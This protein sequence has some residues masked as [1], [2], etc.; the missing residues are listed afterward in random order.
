MALSNNLIMKKK[1]NFI[2]KYSDYFK[3]LL[4]ANKIHFEITTCD[5]VDITS[6]MVSYQV[7]GNRDEILLCDIFNLY[8]GKD[9]QKQ[10]E[11]L[12][13]F[14]VPYFSIDSIINI[15]GTF[16]ISNQYV[17]IFT[18]FMKDH[19][20]NFRIVTES[21]YSTRID[22]LLNSFTRNMILYYLEGAGITY[23]INFKTFK[24]TM[25]YMY[26][27]FRDRKMNSRYAGGHTQIFKNKESNSM[28]IKDVIFNGPATIV[29]WS[30]G[31]KTVVKCENETFDPEKGLAMAISKK[32][33]GNHS[34]YYNQFK[35]WIPE[36]H[37]TDF[38][39]A[40]QNVVKT[41]DDIKK[42]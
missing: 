31:T 11:R 29:M 39:T 23:E 33:F 26:G 24:E 12:S 14:T 27:Y 5:I 7:T 16:Y 36:D 1:Y 35:K 4:H 18:S 9:N 40:C 17:E 21:G 20:I 37:I 3:K 25:N 2:N 34:S 28:Y 10:C 38:D 13:N 15:C 6:L 42:A 32:F 30:D 22:V 19:D 8:A 41:F